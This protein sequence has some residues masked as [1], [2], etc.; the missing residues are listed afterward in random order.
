MRLLSTGAAGIRAQQ[1][2]LDVVGDNMANANTTGFK[3]SQPDFAEA[4][5]TELRPANVTLNG[6]P[7]GATLNVGAGVFYNAIGTDFKQ[8][9]MMTTDRS[10]DVAINGSGFFEVTTA[11]GGKAYTR[12]GNFQVDA[13]GNLCD[14]NGNIVTLVDDQGNVMPNGNLLNTQELEIGSDGAVTAMLAAQR[15]SYGQIPLVVF[16]NQEGLQ[17]MGSNLYGISASSGAA[18]FAKAGTT[19]AGSLQSKALEASNVDLAANM[20][21]LIQVQRAYQM[22]SRMVSD[23]DQ[24]WGIANSLRR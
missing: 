6:A 13:A 14:T 22:N 7:V 2:A 21:D 17:K 8:G 10:A 1:V 16:P 12:D 3:A 19:G 20:T 11:N 15:M 9:A 24:M 23:G 5:A 18:Q 4:L